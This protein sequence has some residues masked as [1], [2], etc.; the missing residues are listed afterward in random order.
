M[1]DDEEEDNGFFLLIL[2]VLAAILLVVTVVARSGDDLPAATVTG[3]APEETTTT[4]APAPTTEAPATTEAAAPETTEAPTTTAAPAAFTI[5]DALNESGESG[6]FALIGGPLGLQEALEAVTDEDGNPIETTLF[7]PSDA[8]LAAY[9]PEAIGALASDPAAAATVVGF[10]RLPG[11]VTAADL[12]A[13]DGQRVQTLAGLPIDVTVVDG[14]VVLNGVT[15]VIAA[16]IEADNGVVHIVDLV[17]DPPTINEVLDLDNI[18]FE[19]NSAVITAAGQAELQ[20]A[21]EF[22]TENEG[23]TARIEGHT[24]TDGGD[25]ANL[26]LSQARAESVLA[27]LGANS[28]DEARF[29]AVG[30][31]ETQPILVDGVEDKAASRRIEFNVR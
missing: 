9:G 3:D 11:N 4:E 22:F 12:I 8:A 27:F 25:E 15:T 16:D 2:G 24:D 21:V 28:V 7:A 26:A 17:L 13:L 18:E 5:W 10:H 1:F 20:R 23:V 19:V 29:E 31:G 14:N 30:F 6:Q